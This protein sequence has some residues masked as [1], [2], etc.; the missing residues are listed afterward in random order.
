[1]VYDQW[2]NGLGQ[3]DGPARLTILRSGDLAFTAKE[4]NFGY[5]S[6]PGSELRLRPGKSF[7]GFIGFD[8]F[9]DPERVAALPNKKLEFGVE[10]VRCEP[11]IG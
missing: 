2:P 3:L 7:E 11:G 10:P 6:G 1:M 4:S 8:Q 9:G 5:P